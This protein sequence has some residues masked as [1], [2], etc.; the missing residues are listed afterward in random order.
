MNITVDLQ[1][2]EGLLSE[3]NVIG[4]TADEALGKLEKF[5]DESTVTDLGELR[6]DRTSARSAEHTSRHSPLGNAR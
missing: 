5:L 2:R 1:P 4:L 3:L 6:I